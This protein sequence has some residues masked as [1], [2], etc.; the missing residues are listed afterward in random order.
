[1]IGFDGKYKITD[2]GLSSI[3]ENSDSEGKIKGSPIFMAPELFLK[4]GKS[5]INNLNDVYSFGVTLY[6]LCFKSFPFIS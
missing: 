1:M 4:D 2:F 5:K 6:F 3:V